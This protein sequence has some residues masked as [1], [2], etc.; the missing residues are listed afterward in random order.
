MVLLSGC[1]VV[2]QMAMAP[3]ARDAAGKPFNLPPAGMAV[4][5]FYNPLASGSGV[6][7]GRRALRQHSDCGLSLAA[8]RRRIW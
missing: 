1:G 7:A 4:L 3:P 6:L 5:Y 2:A 8:V